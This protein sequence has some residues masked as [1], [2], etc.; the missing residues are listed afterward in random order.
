MKT[1]PG[2]FCLFIYFVITRGAE[3]SDCDHFLVRPRVLEPRTASA[4]RKGFDK[5]KNSYPVCRGDY[6]CYS[7]YNLRG[8]Y[9]CRGDFNCRG[10]Q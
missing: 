7:D 3:H 10:D 1:S 6:D 2:E 8:D 5:K 9:T 4:R